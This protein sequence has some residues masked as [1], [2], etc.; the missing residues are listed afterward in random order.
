[1]IAV[2]SQ[3][4]SPGAVETEIQIAGGFV[5]LGNSWLEKKGYPALKDAD[6]AQTVMFLLMTPFSVNLTEIIIK[7]TGETF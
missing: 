2:L 6:V 5:P 4:I 3:E 1:M 7:P